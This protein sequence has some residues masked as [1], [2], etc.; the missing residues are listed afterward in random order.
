MT[1]NI[2]TQKNLITFKKYLIKNTYNL[3]SGY[4]KNKYNK[5]IWLYYFYV[6]IKKYVLSYP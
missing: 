5:N 2:L 3:K 4:K 6:F 1:F